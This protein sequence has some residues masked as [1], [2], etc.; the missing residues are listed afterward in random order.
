MR[1]VMLWLL[2]ASAGAANAQG[3]HRCVDTDG[4]VTFT[5]SGCGTELQ[6]NQIYDATNAPPSGGK[7]VVPYG[8]APQVRQQAS[9]RPRYKVVGLNGHCR[10]EASSG[11]AHRNGYPSKGM[12][13]AQVRA[14][15]GAPDTVSAS[16]NGYLR[17]AW[18]SNERQPYR[19]VTYDENRCVAEVFVTQTYSREPERRQP[20]TRANTV[21]R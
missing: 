11:D 12:S 15:Y 18:N 19:S 17:H 8:H 7:E 16:S 4:A 21:R 13:V 10:V 20:G 1:S 9:E 3:V 5:Q 6:S 14:M 2:L